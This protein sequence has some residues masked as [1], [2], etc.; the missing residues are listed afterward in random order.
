MGKVVSFIHPMT[1]AER[2]EW[3]G[4]DERIKAI[5]LR[6]AELYRKSPARFD[7][8]MMGYGWSEENRAKMVRYIKA[9]EG[10]EE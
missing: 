8:L 1:E 7:N 9:Q 3:Q 6:H 2:Q 4:S 5:A 10:A